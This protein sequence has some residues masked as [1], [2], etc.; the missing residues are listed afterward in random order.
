MYHTDYTLVQL[1]HDE[2]LRAAA[3]HRLVAEAHEGGKDERAARAPL[4]VR[5]LMRL[6]PKRTVA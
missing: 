4:R 3:R 2:N 1:M 5:T 6:L